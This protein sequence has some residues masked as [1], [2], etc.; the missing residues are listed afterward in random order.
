MIGHI[1]RNTHGRHAGNAGPKRLALGL[2][3]NKPGHKLKPAEPQHTGRHCPPVHTGT[4]GPLFMRH[5][6]GTAENASD[7]PYRPLL[8][9]AV[10]ADPMR[11]GPRTRRSGARGMH[12]LPVALD[13]C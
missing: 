5:P 9:A 2:C 10:T 3:W 7:I 11:R 4:T 6:E 1:R 8:S 12:L 13:G